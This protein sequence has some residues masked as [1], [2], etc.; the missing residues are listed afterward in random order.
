ML[1]NKQLFL[2][3][4]HL[5]HKLRCETGHSYSIRYDYDSKLDKHLFMAEL[6]SF[7]ST[8]VVKNHSQVISLTDEEI[9]YILL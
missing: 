7:L 5:H 4:R 2:V 3:T 9:S 6:L 8:G 1:D